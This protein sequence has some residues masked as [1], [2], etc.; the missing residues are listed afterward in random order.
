MTV[1]PTYTRRPPSADPAPPAVPAVP[2]VLVYL[3]APQD[4]SAPSADLAGLARA[5]E[6]LVHSLAPDVV[7]RVTVAGPPA[8]GPSARSGPPG[9]D[10]PPEP[11]PEGRTRLAEGLWL[12][13]GGRTLDVGGRRLP[14]TRREFELLAFLERRRGVAVSRRE[15]MAQVWGSGYL[16]GDRTIDVHVR[17]LRVKLGRHHDRIATLRGYGYRFD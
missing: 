7:T 16:A 13:H 2:A 11:P 9:R 6:R 8:Q 3:G 12:D 10:V 15:L 5:V 17:R 14:L 1:S 4:G